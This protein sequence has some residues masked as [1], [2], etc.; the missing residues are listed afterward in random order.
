MR[1]AAFTASGVADIA[2]PGP[3]RHIL[4]GALVGGPGAPDDH[5]YVDDRSNYITNEVALDYNAG[6]TGALAALVEEHDGK[7]LDV[8]PP[9]ASP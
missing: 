4:Y 1:I 2:D 6:F 7:P 9:P 3:N 8:F 5:S